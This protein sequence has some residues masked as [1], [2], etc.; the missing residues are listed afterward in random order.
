[1]KLSGSITLSALNILYITLP[2][3]ETGNNNIIEKLYCQVKYY[4]TCKMRHFTHKALNT[5]YHY[6]E[7]WVGFEEAG[8]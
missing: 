5:G 4:N 8:S 6:Y 2:V 3:C 1:M 7:E